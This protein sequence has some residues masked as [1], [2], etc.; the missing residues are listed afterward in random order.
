MQKNTLL[1]LIIW[2][3]FTS[4]LCGQKMTDQVSLKNG[5][6]IKGIITEINPSTG[7]K[8][9]TIDGS[10]WFF[11]NEEID[12][13]RKVSA[14]EKNHKQP[15]D[16]P[17]NGF[18]AIAKAGFMA[19]GGTN[20]T[21]SPFSFTL[22]ANYQ[23]NPHFTCALGG[24]IEFF[25]EP[26]LPLFAE[27]TIH[28]SNQHQTPYLY[29]LGGYALAL[30]DRKSTYSDSYD[31]KGGILYGGGIGYRIGLNSR[32]SFLMQAGYRYQELKNNYTLNE[33]YDSELINKY[34]RL[35]LQ[36]GLIIH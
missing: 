34:N 31:S 8:I 33:N 23:I 2:I 3:L 29:M 16:T 1:T 12:I 6:I 11:K 17:P 24:G 21:P 10:I 28:L 19:A 22:S 18:Y 5:S 7:I 13:I 35:S 26:T 15:L 36:I 30:E 4:A 14:K 9:E 25:D 27:W 32:L 20:D